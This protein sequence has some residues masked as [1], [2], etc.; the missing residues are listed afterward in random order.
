MDDGSISVIELHSHCPGQLSSV[1]QFMYFFEYPGAEHDPDQPLYGDSL[2]TNTAMFVAGVSVGHQGMMQY[3]RKNIIKWAN[4]V[5]PGSGST[6][7]A[8][9]EGRAATPVHSRDSPLGLAIWSSGQLDYAI[10]RLADPLLRALTIVYEQPLAVR[11]G[12]LYQLR[13][14]LVRF[15]AAA[16]PFLA[17]NAAFRAHFRNEWER[18][19]V[20]SLLDERPRGRTVIDD[21]VVDYDMFS[22]LGR[23]GWRKVTVGAGVT[24]H[25]KKRHQPSLSRTFS[26]LQRLS[27]NE[28]SWTTNSP[29]KSLCD[30]ASEFDGQ[31]IVPETEAK[32]KF[33]NKANRVGKFE[34]VSGNGQ[35]NWETSLVDHE[36]TMGELL[37]GLDAL[38]ASEMST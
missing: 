31:S 2:L 5:L 14:V 37:Q 16:L 27:R 20:L 29:E 9:G 6:D 12:P 25:M 36:Q 28:R 22:D 30:D 34:P 15:V 38:L 1:L 8:D 4:A 24:A 11:A 26:L 7:E 23:V 13:L 32:N 17:V 33:G 35:K 3:A 18:P 19:L 10:L 21:I